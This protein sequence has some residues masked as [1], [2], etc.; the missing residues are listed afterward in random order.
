MRSESQVIRQGCYCAQHLEGTGACQEHTLERAFRPRGLFSSGIRTTRSVFVGHSDHDVC[1]HRAFR[2]RG[3]FSS[4]IPATRSV[5]IGHS[6]LEVC[7]RRDSV[8]EV[9]LPWAF[10]CAPMSCAHGLRG[11]Q[12]LTPSR[13]LPNK[14][15]DV[16]CNILL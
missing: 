8:P 6:V 11:D 10:C 2:P 5:F 16:F 13:P 9:C 15:P 14:G 7:F 1:F 4:G 3:L 12:A